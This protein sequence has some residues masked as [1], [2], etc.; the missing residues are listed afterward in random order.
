MHN[1]RFSKYL[2]KHYQIL[3]WRA[4]VEH[5]LLV[6]FTGKYNNVL[7]PLHNSQVMLSTEFLQTSYENSDTKR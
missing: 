2:N 1:F 7:K 3:E 6:Q 5:N 4:K